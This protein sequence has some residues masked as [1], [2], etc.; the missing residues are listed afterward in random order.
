MVSA[1]TD[2]G[3]EHESLCDHCSF[4]S[5]CYVRCCRGTDY[6]AERR[7]SHYGT[8]NSAHF[9]YDQLHDVLQFPRG[10]LSN[11]LLRSPAAY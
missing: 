3:E 4:G 7:C 5:D 10:E 8:V 1:A 11:G 9:H 2:L 6:D